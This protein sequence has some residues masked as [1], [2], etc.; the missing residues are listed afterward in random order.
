MKIYIY[1]I[2]IIFLTTSC[3]K[4]VY[5]SRA[6]GH[7]IDATTGQPVAGAWVELTREKT[8][9]L[10]RTTIE[11]EAKTLT[12]EDGSFVID[13]RRSRGWQYVVYSGKQDYFFSPSSEQESLDFIGNKNLQIK[14]APRAELV[15]D[16][17]N[18]KGG[19]GIDFGTLH[20]R[21][22]GGESL[23]SGVFESY[24][25]QIQGNIQIGIYYYIQDTFGNE[26]KYDTSIYCP[27]FESTTFRIDY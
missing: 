19:S 8:A 25:Y 22:G 18:T 27:A 23:G 15:F 24:S 17:R 1:I 5:N 3:G 2:I 6:Q 13:Y 9:F 16:I 21:G 11:T 26:V 7:I 12:K 4:T 20:S 14:L 10:G